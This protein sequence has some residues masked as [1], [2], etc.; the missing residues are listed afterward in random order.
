MT[1]SLWASVSLIEQYCPQTPAISFNCGLSSTYL[2]T[3]ALSL[4][5]LCPAL[6]ML[7][8]F[9]WDRSGKCLI[10]C[11]CSYCLPHFMYSDS[12]PSPQDNSIWKEGWGHGMWVNNKIEEDGHTSINSQ[13]ESHCPLTQAM[14]WSPIYSTTMPLSLWALSSVLDKLYLFCY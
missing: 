8:P 1:L 4:C 2:T 7:Y 3:M 9:C 13:I 12:L 10:W 14:F 6:D 5:A 11:K